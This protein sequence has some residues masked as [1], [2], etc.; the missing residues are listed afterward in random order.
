MSSIPYSRYVLGTIPWYS[1]LIVIGIVL[2]IILASLEERRTSLPKDTVID[3]A[4]WILPSGIIGARIYYVIFSWNQFRNDI[5]SVFRIWE[6]GIAIYGGI[7]A[8]LIV[9]LIFCRARHLPPLQLCDLIVPG[10]VLAQ[11]IGRWGNWFNIEA[12][13]FRITRPELCFFPFAVEVPADQN[14]WHLATFFYESV[15][16]FIVFIFLIIS[17]RKY[18]RYQGDI[19]FFYLF[20]YACGRLIIEEMRI[21]S[22]YAASGIRISQLLS[23]LLSIAVLFRYAILLRKIHPVPHYLYIMI[24]LAVSASS[25]V[26]LYSFS[27]PVF[28][29]MGRSG[30]LFALSLFSLLMFIILFVIYHVVSV[31]EVIHADN[32]A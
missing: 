30:I 14:N 32:E 18:F 23:V 29:F 21:D 16:D 6:G 11:C 5:L 22:L 20:L 24:P 17:R 13:G 7:I 15:W 26:L 8:G 3:L 10:L 1:L 31:R 4:L 12:Y 9:L 25:I 28:S 27:V 19:F 2:A